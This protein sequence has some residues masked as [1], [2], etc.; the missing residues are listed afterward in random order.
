MV[1]D[2]CLY[3]IKILLSFYLFDGVLATNI[4]TLCEQVLIAVV[5][6]E[7]KNNGHK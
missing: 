5:V 6:F 4:H 7:K 3:E 2:Y 1:N